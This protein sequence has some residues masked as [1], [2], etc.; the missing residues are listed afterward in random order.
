MGRRLSQLPVQ[1]T[2]YDV[3]AAGCTFPQ[4]GEKS[5]TTFNDFILFALQ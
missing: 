5:E 3:R 4:S 1:H 2:Y